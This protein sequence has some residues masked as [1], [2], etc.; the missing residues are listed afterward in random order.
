MFVVVLQPYSLHLML[1]QGLEEVQPSC[2][3]DSSLGSSNLSWPPLYP[4]NRQFHSVI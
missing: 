1:V 3:Q 2:V 4:T